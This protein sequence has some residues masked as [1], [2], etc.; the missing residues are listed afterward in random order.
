MSRKKD[1]PE[2]VKLAKE[3]EGMLETI[4]TKQKAIEDATLESV[5]AEVPTLPRPK[6]HTRVHLRGHLD[7]VND[8]HFSGDARL[9]EKENSWSYGGKLDR[10]MAHSRHVTLYIVNL[11][12]NA[13]PEHSVAVVVYAFVFQFSSRSHC[14]SGSLDG[15][16]IIWDAWTGNK[17][18]IIPLKSS[19]VMISVWDVDKG[20][21]KTEFFGHEGDITA[22]S[23]IP[24]DRNTC[25]SASA[26]K[27]AKI[28][29]LRMGGAT[30]CAQTFFGHESDVN[31]AEYYPTAE[32]VVTSSDDKTAKLFDR[33]SDHELATY[34]TQSAASSLT[35][36]ALSVSGRILFVGSDDS[37]VHMWDTLKCQ[38]LGNLCAHESKITGLSMTSNGV[39]LATSSWDHSVRIW[40]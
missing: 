19:W 34:K 39:A 30:A 18:Q 2:H 1:D 33:R 12:V 23:I 17:T 21:Q 4:R 8:V 37:S 15:K 26:D 38:Y 10:W 11:H 7:K 13:R 27:T 35:R 20:K 6:L 9:D 36:C 22:I 31:G 25:L 28:W 32:G 40:G 3:L 16:L 14:V 5:C 24:K 29:D